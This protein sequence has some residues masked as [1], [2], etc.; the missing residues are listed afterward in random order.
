MKERLDKLLVSLNYFDT[1]ERAK[2][3]I[4]AGLVQVND[5]VRDKAGDLVDTEAMI[6]V[7]GSDL[8][9]VSRGGLKLEKG[10]AVFDLEVAGKAFIDIGSS[11]GGF[12][13]CL[14]QNGA[15]KV[16]AV[17]VGYGQL[18]WK[19]RTDSR[20]VSME[21]TNFRYLTTENISE[22]VDGT[23][24]DVSFISITKLIPAIKLFMKPGARGIWLIKPQFEA[25]RERIGKNGVIRDKK[26]HE[27]ILLEVMTAIE[28][29]GFLIKGLDFSPI[30]GPKGNIEFLVFVENTE[31]E[32]EGNWASLIH[33][34]VTIAHESCKKKKEPQ[35]E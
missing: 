6:Q 4:M 29:Q 33:Q 27:S 5:Q 9:Y 34:V 28:K 26:V 15:T 1:R 10:L 19:L 18:D 25:G 24:M 11:T 3:A 35:D 7:K 30:Q 20:V 8:P 17:D 32:I 23:V 12:T 31:P 14:L 2:K 13:D 16:Y 22:L 21:R